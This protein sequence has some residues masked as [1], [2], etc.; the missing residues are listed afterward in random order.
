MRFAIFI[1]FI[2]VTICII[3]GCDNPFAPRLATNQSLNFGLG[4]QTTTDGVFQ[5]FRYAYL[6]KD[7][8]IYGR[9]LAPNFSF[10]YRN[11]DKSLD[12]TWGRD[13][14]MTA[15][16]G[17]FQAAETIDLV[18]NDIVQSSG[19]SVLRDMSRGFNLTLTFSPTDIV[20]VQ[21]RVN[22]R[23]ARPSPSDKWQIIIWRDESNF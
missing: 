19:D 10:I 18:W 2:T 11:Y 20:R 3:S 4:D 22:L 16:S 21:G 12:Q 1:T 5:N 13:E 23:L 15:T 17:L 9:L 6:T 14:D 8:L 7:T